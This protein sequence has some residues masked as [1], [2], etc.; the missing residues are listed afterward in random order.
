MQVIF[1]DLDGTLLDRAYSYAAA[2]PALALMRELDVPLVF[3][4]S[5]TRAE[6]EYWRSRLNN[7]HP[8]II[9]NGGAL[10]VPR[11]Y[12]PFAIRAPVY[13]DGYAV[14]EFGDPY[15]ELVGALRSASLESRCEVVG[16]HRLSASEISK[17]YG[18]SGQ[19][20][21]LA[22]RR[23]YDE[24]FEI[25]GSS[26]AALLAAIER[27]KKRWLQGGRLYHVLGVNDKA[28][29][30]N[31]LTHFY[32]RAVPHVAT[33]G[34]GDGPNDVGFLN[35]VN[36]PVLLRTAMAGKLVK[37]V[38]GARLTDLEGP[39]G[40]NEAVLSLLASHNRGRA[41]EPELSHS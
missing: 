16:F 19:E 12:F 4:S 30:V 38:K 6:I 1:T 13:R 23:E 9:E 32:Q 33:M 5:K 7:R 34:L 39:E 17:R 2:R 27:R 10:Y 20:A 41:L 24:P 21:E 36:T 25:L 31:L 28:H 11:D 8:F 35:S 29:C 22:K 37:A 18:M 14:F 26:G 15:G 3:C 40:W